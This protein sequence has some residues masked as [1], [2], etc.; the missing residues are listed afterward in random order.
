M[1]KQPIISIE[2]NRLKSWAY[3][4]LILKTEWR[5]G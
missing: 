5:S 4:S 1:M 2:I 3:T